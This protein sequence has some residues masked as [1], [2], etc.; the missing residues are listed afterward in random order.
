MGPRFLSVHSTPVLLLLET[1]DSIHSS[2]IHKPPE[3]CLSLF[4]HTSYRT[5]TQVRDNLNFLKTLN[6]SIR[7]FGRLLLTLPRRHLPLFR[8]DMW[9]L[10]CR[11]RV[12]LVQ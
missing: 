8:S 11:L 2:L 3:H 1:L 9:T 12:L 5:S 4:H 7:P 10:T 6:P